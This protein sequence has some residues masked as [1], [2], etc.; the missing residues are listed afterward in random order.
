M[1]EV[2][3]GRDRYYGAEKTGERIVVLAIGLPLRK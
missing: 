1:L 3:P 2:L